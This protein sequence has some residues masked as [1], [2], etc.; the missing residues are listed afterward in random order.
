ML[1][2][3]Q[4]IKSVLNSCEAKRKAINLFLN[5]SASLKIL[6]EGILAG[7]DLKRYKQA[8]MK[9]VATNRASKCVFR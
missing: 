9:Y 7:S 3:I 5:E 1:R 4:H 8:I 6:N 2:P